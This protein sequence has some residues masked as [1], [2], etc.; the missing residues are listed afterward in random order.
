MTSGTMNARTIGTTT[1]GRTSKTPTRRVGTIARSVPGD[2]TASSQ[3]AIGHLLDHRIHSSL[4]RTC[5]LIGS[6]AAG[7]SLATDRIGS[8]GAFGSNNNGRNG[9]ASPERCC[10]HQSGLQK[11][12][13][14]ASL[15]RG[16]F[17]RDF[18]RCRTQYCGNARAPRGKQAQIRRQQEKGEDRSQPP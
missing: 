5:W 3:N 10:H 9:G 2:G 14:T 8:A 6:F 17:N 4:R 7:T 16:L 18:G 11:G 15:R 13:S 12:R 1:A